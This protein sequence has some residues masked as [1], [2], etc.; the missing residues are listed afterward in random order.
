M[1]TTLFSSLSK[2]SKE[3]LIK[4]LKGFYIPY[5]NNLDIPSDATFGCEI[6]FNMPGYDYQY[7]QKLYKQG[8]NNPAKEFLIS[9]G[10]PK[11]WHVDKELPY[12]FEI[13]S[14]VLCDEVKTWAELESVLKFYLEHGAYTTMDSGAH[15]HVGKQLLKKNPDYWCTFLKL[16][17]IFEE[18]I[19]SFS[20]GEEYYERFVFHDYSDYSKEQLKDVIHNIEIKNYNKKITLLNDKIYSI[21]FSPKDKTINDLFSSKSNFKDF[22]VDSTIEIRCPNGTLNKIIWQNNINFFV[23]M[24][25]SCSNDG[26][27]KELI[28]YLYK[29]LVLDKDSCNNEKVLILCDIVF[30]NDLDKFCFL[31]QYYKDFNKPKEQDPS[32]KSK[33]FWK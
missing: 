5:R 4:D 18:E 16:W 31:R 21:N 19:I 25:L 14:D 30:N 15:V 8:Y 17:S 7:I 22:N 33:R 11:I 13:I 9:I 20:N 23:K 32:I 12:Q 27:K 26:Q 2:S 24:I 10:Y 29:K 6:E 28:D 1:S 3:R